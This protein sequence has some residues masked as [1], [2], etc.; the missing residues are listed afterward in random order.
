MQT[1][2]FQISNTHTKAFKHL[3]SH[4]EN[5][6]MTLNLGRGVIVCK[7]TELLRVRYVPS[8]IVRVKIENLPSSKK[9]HW[10]ILSECCDFWSIPSLKFVSVNL[11]I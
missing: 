4:T 7:S 2:S 6:I 5:K 10:F 11:V 3:G 1:L 8:C 9:N